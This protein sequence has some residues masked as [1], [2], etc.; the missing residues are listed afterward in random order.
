MRAMVILMLAASAVAQAE[1]EVSSDGNNPAILRVTEHQTEEGRVVVQRTVL[2]YDREANPHVVNQRFLK[3]GDH[4]RVLPDSLS[5]TEVAIGEALCAAEG[6]HYV[7]HLSDVRISPGTVQ[8]LL[9]EYD[10]P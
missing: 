8:A 9:C 4:Y 10:R 3:D 7:T 5:E 2:I 6:S 1:T